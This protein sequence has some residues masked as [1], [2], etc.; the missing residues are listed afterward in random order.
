M[1]VRPTLLDGPYDQARAGV[2]ALASF[3]A[4]TQ[5]LGTWLGSTLLEVR[6]NLLDGPWAK[7]ENPT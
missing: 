6:T 5:A 7:L 3:S 4:R 2:D 1:E